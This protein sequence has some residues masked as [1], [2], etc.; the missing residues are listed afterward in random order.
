MDHMTLIISERKRPLELEK[1]R[2]RPVEIGHFHQNYLVLVSWA[3]LF[4][5]I[6]RKMYVLPK[7]LY[8]ILIKN[9][10]FMEHIVILEVFIIRTII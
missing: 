7:K 1:C 3:Y 4:I 6:Y 2:N 8:M 5:R 9:V 10:R